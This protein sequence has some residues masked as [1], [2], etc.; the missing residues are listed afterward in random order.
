MTRLRPIHSAAVLLA[1]TSIV[2]LP[3]LAP[4][5]ASAQKP[6]P[7]IVRTTSAH[8]A[9]LAKEDGLSGVVLMAK[10]GKPILESAYG[11]SNL[12]D[13]VPNRVDTKF[14]MASMGKMFTAVA[15]LQLVEAGRI[16]LDDTVGKYLPNYPGKA[17]RDDVTVKELLTHTS[18]MGNFW[19][20]L[21]D[22]AKDRYVSVSDYVPL[23]A[24]QPLLF[25]PG[26]SFAYSN[27]GYTVL[28]LIIEAV[29]GH[30]YF[31]YVR[32]HIY[33]PCRMTNTDAYALNAPIA[34]LAMGY[35]RSADTPGQLLSNIYLIPFRGSPAGGSYTT[36]GDMLR[37]A[38][39]LMSHKLLDRAHTDALT[40]G[41]V[42]YGT[43]RYAYGFTVDTANGHKLIGHGGGN[44]GIADELMIFPDLGYTVV[45]LT[46]GDVEN[47]W[48]IESFMKRS[49]MGP[50]PAS[51][52]YDFTRAA[53]ATAR[54]SGFAAGAKM[55]NDHPD[56]PAIRAGLLEQIGYKLL[57]E[58]KPD[59]AIAVFRLYATAKPQDEYA[60]LG[61]AKAYERANATSDAID[62]Y[63]KYLA[64]EPADADTKA[65]LVRLK[66]RSA[67]TTPVGH[68]P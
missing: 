13:R 59:Q 11:F 39:A 21:A 10:D 65:T 46:N 22:K 32:D 15:V 1:M 41:T 6:T 28:G 48:D 25:A 29:S 43:R 49:L 23:F 5:A 64:L 36:A 3:A 14:N 55:L 2:T 12:G 33:H 9:T 62:A 67:G 30:T 26:T 68:A 4:R 31:D 61:L 17:V 54:V 40:T 42:D 58:R 8:L 50:S 63:T 16:A 24:D 35:Y 7:E 57:W 18:G 52:S 60:Y 27:N 47:F 44:T 20:Q 51:E 56:H 37:F 34:N 19:E 66:Q 53:I 45:V 38:N